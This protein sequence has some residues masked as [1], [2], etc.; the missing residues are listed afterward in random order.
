[1]VCWYCN[2]IWLWETI[3]ICMGW[4]MV[5]RNYEQ[6]EWFGQHKDKWSLVNGSGIPKFQKMVEGNHCVA[7]HANTS[8][9]FI[10]LLQP[11]VN[12]LIRKTVN[13]SSTKYVYVMSAYSKG[14]IRISPYSLVLWIPIWLTELTGN[15]ECGWE[16]R[17]PIDLR[18]LLSKS[19]IIRT[20][21][22]W[23]ICSS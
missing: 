20:L 1:M 12:G 5:Y 19:G 2:V 22:L 23:S 8:Y 14:P 3:V 17:L 16:Y 18:N 21:W 13:E 11:A 4:R 15:I 9:S 10:V 6:W 7:D